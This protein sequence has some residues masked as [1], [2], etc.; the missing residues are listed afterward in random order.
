MTI[1]EQYEISKAQWN[2]IIAALKNEFPQADDIRVANTANNLAFDVIHSK[3]KNI[4]AKNYTAWVS[5]NIKYPHETSKKLV[6]C[7]K[8]VFYMYYTEEY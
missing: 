6:K 3:N 8:D 2:K 4:A 5:I 7:E 1:Y